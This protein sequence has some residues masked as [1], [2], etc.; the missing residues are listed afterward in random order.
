MSRIFVKISFLWGPKHRVYT[1][2][3]FAASV[4]SCYL[5]NGMHNFTPHLLF[6]VGT[7]YIAKWLSNAILNDLHGIKIFLNHKTLSSKHMMIFFREDMTSFLNYVNATPRALFAWRGS[8]DLCLSIYGVVTSTYRVI[9][10]IYYISDLLQAIW[11]VDGGHMAVPH[12][13]DIARWIASF[14]ICDVSDGGDVE[15]VRKMA[16]TVRRIRA[17]GP[18]LGQIECWA[19]GYKANQL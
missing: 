10:S 1:T 9:I 4:T 6:C 2:A 15:D 8:Y 5:H 18:N 11:L 19:N 7:S 17:I 14:W 16:S 12:F 13:S 3:S